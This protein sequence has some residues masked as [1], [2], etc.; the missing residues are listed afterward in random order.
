MSR[1]LDRQYLFHDF[2]FH[3]VQENQRRRM[4][5]AIEQADAGAIRRG[6]VD[7]VADD[8]AGRFRLDAPILTE[9][10]VSLAVEEAQVDATG[11][12]SRAFVGPGPHYVPGIRATY[13]VPYTGEREMF[14][15]RPSTFTTVL[16]AAELKPGELRFVYERTDQNVAGTK[17]SFDHDL[18]EVKRYLGW[19]EENANSFNDSLP[20]L[21][22]QAVAAR[23]QRLAEM[24]RGTQSLGVPIRRS[25]T[26][27]DSRQGVAPRR[28]ATPTT[29]QKPETYDVALSFAGED[30]DY[31]EAVAVTLK[32]AGVSVFYDK[33]EQATLWGKNLID[34][35]AEIYQKRTRYVV[36]FI[37]EHY[38]KKAWPTHERQHAQ[39][40]ALVARADYI[41]P[42]RFDDADVPGLTTTVAYVDLRTTAQ[43]DFVTLILEKL[44]KVAP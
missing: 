30:R 7:V 41:L 23:R 43:R 36:M 14:R 27:M 20:P 38:V 26:G 19:L 2:D 25:E 21:A 5:A 16:P 9:G 18:R 31:V 39:A 8:F 13:Y 24:D 44:G 6:D 32:A 1:G 33:F 37:S 35:L 10:A 28:P 3:A 29:E 34:H 42:A 17:Q 22:R 11:D 15:C 40:R 12:F 4:L